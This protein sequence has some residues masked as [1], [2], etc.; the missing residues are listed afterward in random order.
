MSGT[1]AITS[2]E[3]VDPGSYNYTGTLPVSLVG[4]TDVTTPTG[5]GATLD[6]QFGN[7]VNTALNAGVD[8][9]FGGAPTGGSLIATPY[10]SGNVDTPLPAGRTVDI[11][12]S[13]PDSY[14][15]Q[16]ATVELSILHQND[17]DLIA[18]LIA[19]DGTSVLL[20]SGVGTSGSTPHANFTNTVFDDA[21]TIPIQEAATSR[22]T[23]IGAGPFNPQ[24]PLSTLDSHGSFGTWILEITS[25]SST[26]N[27]TLV[28]WTLSLKSSVEGVGVANQFT[29]PFRIFTQDPTNPVSQQSWTAVG[30]A[31][32]QNGADAGRTGGLAIDP[33]DPSGNTVYAA[34]ASGG[35]WKT[36]DFMTTSPN[37][38]T[39]I[40]LTNVGP[41]YSLDVG[42]IAVFGRNNDPNQSIIFVATGEGSTL[43]AGVGFLRSMDGGKTWRLLDS[44]VNV[45]ATGNVLPVSSP[46]R[47]HK[48]LGVTS[49][50]VIV[51]PVAEANGDVIVYAAMG[52][53]VWR[54]IDSGGTWT[55][56]QAGV[57]SDVVLAAGS[58][59]GGGTTGNLQVLYAAVEGKGVYFTPDAPAAAA[60]ILQLGNSG[61]P[62]RVSVDG[63]NPVAI[64]VN[65][66]NVN[67]LQAGTGR[68]VLAA[69]AYTG[70][71]LE[72]TLYEGWV[73]AAV[74]TAGGAFGGL[75]VTKDFGQNWTEIRLPVIN[76]NLPDQTSTNND[77]IAAN[78]S[79]TGDVQ[80]PQGNYNVTMAVDPNNANIVYLGGSEDASPTLNG[81]GGGF[82]RIDA[83]DVVDPYSVDAYDNN[84]DVVGQTQLASQGAVTLGPVS[85][86]RLSRTRRD[87]IPARVRCTA[88]IDP[89]DLSTYTTPITAYL[90]MERDPES[91]FES[92]ATLQFTNITSFGNSG[93]GRG[94]TNSF[95]GGGLGEHRPAQPHRLQGPAHR[96]NR[97]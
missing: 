84:N 40:P 64:P 81:L 89:N 74:A 96:R 53:G 18:T 61:T 39:W 7:R 75:Y 29:A 24:L 46:L 38:P 32:I 67:P 15:V 43:S 52:N 13:V 77:T 59:S 22:G 54:S 63:V 47:D 87:S 66:D 95:Y 20:F 5:L 11:P 70:I 12:I 65:N 60:L 86:S 56:L 55:L 6:L 88:C 62:S 16:G 58:A 28:N 9:L 93:R 92:P 26:L 44:T 97:G 69:P 71:P 94:R 45:D 35:V 48:F 68:I 90:N 80:F 23:G 85:S 2:V 31:S 42:S 78:I 27:G 4:V 19:P 17:P 3:L 37:G 51:D 36:T 79:I 72:D 91:P 57:A 25:Q 21:A 10:A 8:L 76:P 1:G 14:L 83:T 30:P 82:I 73:Y 49:F 50:K 33:S 34:G 41:G